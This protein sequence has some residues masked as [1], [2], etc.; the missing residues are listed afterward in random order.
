MIHASDCR[1]GAYAC[2]LRA[3]GVSFDPGV[4][5][6]TP[7]RGKPGSN[8]LHNSWEAGQAVDKRP[9][10]FEMPILDAQGNTMSIKKYAENRHTYDESRR[11]IRE[12]AQAAGFDH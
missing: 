5:R 4:A 1:C 3:K 8:A 9:G 11:A 6:H 7:R 12:K 10:G 2:E